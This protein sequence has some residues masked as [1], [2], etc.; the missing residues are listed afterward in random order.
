MSIKMRIAEAKKKY[1]EWEAN[2]E[3]K[4]LQR[5]RSERIRLEGQA[6]RRSLM[7]KERGRISKARGT[8]SSTSTYGRAK[9]FIATSQKEA[10]RFAKQSGGGGFDIGADPLGIDKPKP[11][12]QKRRRYYYTR[13]KRRRSRATYRRR[14]YPRRRKRRKPKRRKSYDPMGSIDFGF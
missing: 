2:R 5:L 13:R 7:E 11:R 6:K 1:S 4:N 3:A 10:Q 14:S 8:I 9:Q 12:K